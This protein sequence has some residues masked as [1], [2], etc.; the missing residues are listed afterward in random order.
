MCQSS[1]NLKTYCQKVQIKILFELFS[2]EALQQ[3]A[4]SQNF[5]N[6]P[7]K[8]CAN[9]MLGSANPEHIDSS[10]RSAA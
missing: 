5:S 1:L 4:W 9:R 8:T 2:V 6:W 7:A 3:I 10:D